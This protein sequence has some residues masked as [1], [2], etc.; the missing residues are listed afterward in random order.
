M[1][2]GYVIIFFPGGFETHSGHLHHQHHHFIPYRHTHTQHIRTQNTTQHHTRLVF[3]AVSSF[4]KWTR[5]A[6]VLLFVCLFFWLKIQLLMLVHFSLWC[7]WLTL[8]TFFFFVCYS[9]IGSSIYQ[10]TQNNFWQTYVRSI[11]STQKWTITYLNRAHEI[12]LSV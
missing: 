9:K 5:C 4:I 7:K 11:E 2:N 3:T 10:D 8:H 6:I 12:F 1:K